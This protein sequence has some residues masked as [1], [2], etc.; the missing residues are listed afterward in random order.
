MSS[1]L[2][3]SILSAYAND[4]NCRSIRDQL[5]ADPASLSPQWSL[6]VADGLIRTLKVVC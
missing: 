2:R 3:D 1:Q 5:L 6:Q 4:S